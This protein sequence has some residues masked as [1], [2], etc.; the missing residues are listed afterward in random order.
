MKALVVVSR[1]VGSSGVAKGLAN[2]LDGGTACRRSQ[3]WTTLSGGGEGFLSVRLSKGAKETEA[4]MGG[5]G[6]EEGIP[7]EADHVEESEPEPPVGVE[8]GVGAFGDS[9]S[10]MASRIHEPTKES[11]A[12]GRG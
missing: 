1:W 10:L 3:F 9:F 11:I 8:A 6:V 7:F 2:V 4:V 5:E 12:F